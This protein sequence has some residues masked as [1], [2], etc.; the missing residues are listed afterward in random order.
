MRQISGKINNLSKSRSISLVCRSDPG[1]YW[2]HLQ[3]GHLACWWVAV[4]SFPIKKHHSN[5]RPAGLYSLL[6]WNYVRAIDPWGD[7]SHRQSWVEGDR[8][9]LQPSL[10]L[11]HSLSITCSPHLLFN[12][13]PQ[14]RLPVLTSLLEPRLF[15]WSVTWSECVYSVAANGG[16]TEA[17]EDAGMRC[18][19]PPQRWLSST[20]PHQ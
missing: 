7:R 1:I 3:T 2:M 8:N 12:V 19:A 6:A 17:S 18:E 10:A 14:R 5:S 20:C 13:F 15:I 16:Y 4:L 11:M 9:L